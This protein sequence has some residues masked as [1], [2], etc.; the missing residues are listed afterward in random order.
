MLDFLLIALVSVALV[1]FPLHF[2]IVAGIA[3][4]I[5]LFKGGLDFV[6]KLIP[7][8]LVSAILPTAYAYYMTV[9][10]SFIDIGINAVSLTAGYAAGSLLST[11]LLPV[12]LF[13]KL[14]KTFLGLIKR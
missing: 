5:G 4:L 13:G 8:V 6:F 12:K 1:H 14:I 7:V 9:P 11:V 10:F 3:F 2:L